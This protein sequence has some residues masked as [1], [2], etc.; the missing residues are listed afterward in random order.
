MFYDLIIADQELKVVASMR[1]ER[2]DTP[3]PS[4]LLAQ[5][6]RSGQ[7]NTHVEKIGRSLICPVQDINPLFPLWFRGRVAGGFRWKSLPG[8]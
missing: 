1:P 4:D 7:F 8:M 3:F 6:I 5:S 2:L